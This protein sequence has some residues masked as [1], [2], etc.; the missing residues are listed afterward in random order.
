MFEK[1]LINKNINLKNMQFIRWS[2]AQV[3][4]AVVSGRRK[5]GCRSR[6]SV[7]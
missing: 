6:E 3:W 1:R 5:K 2:P 7:I 4:C